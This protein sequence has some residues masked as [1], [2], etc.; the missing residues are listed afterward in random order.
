MH[1]KEQFSEIILNLGQWFTRFLIWSSGISPVWCSRTI[2]EEHSCERYMK[3]G[4]VF[5]EISFK[6]ISYL[7]LWQPFC[8]VDLNHLCNFGRRYL[9]EQFCEIILNLGQ[10]IWRRCC[11]KIIIWSSGSHTIG[12]SRTIY[13]FLKEGIMGNIHVK[14]YEIR[15]SGSGGDVV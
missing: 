14:L 6:D 3:L 4:Q 10:W 15:T 11:L 8:S 2:Y 12:W 1:H 13:A 5:L 9:E 7:E